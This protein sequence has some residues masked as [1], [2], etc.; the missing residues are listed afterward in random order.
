VT[1]GQAPNEAGTEHN[2]IERDMIEFDAA[3]RGPLGGVRVLDLSRLVAGN[4]LSLQLADLGAEVTKVEPPQG[5]PLRDW[6]DEGRP[7]FWKVYARN[8]R[9]IVLNLRVAAGKEA[10]L[11]LAER[12]DVLI[13]NFR[14]GTLEQMVLGP[15]VFLA[16]NPD[17]I[18]V[19][20]SGFGQTGP[21]AQLP[22]FGTL[23][24]AMSGL[25]ARTGFPDR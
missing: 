24:E 13:E 23:V 12:A 18:L 5:D 20:I 14:P 19:R 8:K 9:S 10:L 3:Q 11:R 21:Y 22:G 15:D 4:M 7:L 6:L 1:D 17:L 16:R 2:R 25:A